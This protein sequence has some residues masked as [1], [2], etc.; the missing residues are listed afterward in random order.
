MS[1]VHA[2]RLEETV[3]RAMGC[4]AQAAALQTGSPALIKGRT[5]A[6]LGL[7]ACAAPD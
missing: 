4:E 2:T 3:G 7:V 5:Y 1:V 6:G